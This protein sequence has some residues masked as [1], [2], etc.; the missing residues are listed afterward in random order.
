MDTA[1]VSILSVEV[2]TSPKQILLDRIATFAGGSGGI[3]TIVTP[4]PE[5]VMR[6]SRDAAFRDAVNGADIRLPDGIGLIWASQGAIGQ[7]I[8]GIDFMHELVAMAARMGKPVLF[9]G[10]KGTSAVD[11]LSRLTGEFPRLRGVAESGPKL[12]L[13]VDEAYRSYAASLAATVRKE[14]VGFVFVGFGAPKQEWFL[15]ELKR[16]LVGYGPVVIMAVGGSFDV[17]SGTIRRAPAVMQRLGFEWLWRLFLEPWRIARQFD[18]VRFV[19]A[20]ATYRKAAH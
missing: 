15:C 5:I 6:A 17:F 16:E 4:N 10:G 8:A 19:I 18:L 13:S 11:A 20:V 9:T 7:R 12:G 1:S 14:K 3:L 2:T